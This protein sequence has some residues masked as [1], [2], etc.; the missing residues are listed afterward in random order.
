MAHPAAVPCGH[1]VLHPFHCP[2][3]AESSAA[4][5]LRPLLLPAEL[6]PSL[7]ISAADDLCQQAP[8]NSGE[9]S[10]YGAFRSAIHDSTYVHRIRSALHHAGSAIQTA[11]HDSLLAGL[12]LLRADNHVRPSRRPCTKKI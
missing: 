3:S 8:E 9:Q 4:L 12:R 1:G 10:A 2:S 7:C 11:A 5:S 6:R